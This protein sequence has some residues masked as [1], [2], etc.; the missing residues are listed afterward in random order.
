MSVLKYLRS[1][2]VIMWGPDKHWQCFRCHS[3]HPP[4]DMS[5]DRESKRWF[6]A[7]CIHPEVIQTPYILTPDQAA[8]ISLQCERCDTVFLSK[9]KVKLEVDK[10]AFVCER[11]QIDEAYGAEKHR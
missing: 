11:C 8:A 6:C 5:L 2:L 1:L 9:Y 4:S 10:T 3:T 7:T